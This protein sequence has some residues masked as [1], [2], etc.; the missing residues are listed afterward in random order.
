MRGRVSNVP[1]HP[2]PWSG[3]SAGS[4]HWMKPG[5]AEPGTS[6]LARCPLEQGNSQSRMRDREAAGHLALGHEHGLVGGV[7]TSVSSASSSWA[8][9]S[10][11]ELGEGVRIFS[12]QPPLG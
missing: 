8:P 1:P 10:K 9:K 5:S 11:A 3:C 4:G 12:K 7:L 2:L 6:S